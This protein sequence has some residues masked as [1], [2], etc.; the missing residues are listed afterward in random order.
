MDKLGIGKEKT[1]LGKKIAELE[2]ELA[3]LRENL[4]DMD[5]KDRASWG[6]RFVGLRPGG[7]LGGRRDDLSG[8]PWAG[9]WG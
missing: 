1:D 6:D 7:P 4:A 3:I 2:K 8:G 5:K 9:P